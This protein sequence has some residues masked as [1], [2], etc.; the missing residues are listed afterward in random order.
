MSQ[1]IYNTIL[2]ACLSKIGC[3]TKLDCHDAKDQ[4]KLGKARVSEHAL[5]LHLN[6]QAMYSG[7]RVRNAL[8]PASCRKDGSR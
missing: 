1:R 3:Y 6:R 5:S 7:I 2:C 4:E 8:T